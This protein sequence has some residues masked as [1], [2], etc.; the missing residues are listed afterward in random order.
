[1]HKCHD[2]WKNK[3][4]WRASAFTC[5]PPFQECAKLEPNY[6]FDT[7][8]WH[9]NWHLHFFTVLNILE[10]NL[11]Q[12]YIYI[13]IDNINIFKNMYFSKKKISLDKDLIYKRNFYSH[14]KVKVCMFKYGK[15]SIS[16]FWY[17]LWE[18]LQ[19]HCYILQKLTNEWIHHRREWAHAICWY[20][21]QHMWC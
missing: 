7:L 10:Y 19:F 2:W 3:K 17:F 12:R 18:Q 6:N 13:Y 11:N 15:K 16:K 8:T 5:T 9:A 1:M 20:M 21:L 4:K 14:T